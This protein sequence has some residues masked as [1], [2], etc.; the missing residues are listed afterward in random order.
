M[1]C[2]SSGTDYEASTKKIN[3][4]IKMIINDWLFKISKEKL[5]PN[6]STL[7]NVVKNTTTINKIPRNTINQTK[8]GK[9]L[10]FNALVQSSLDSLTLPDSIFKNTLS[11]LQIHNFSL[12]DQKDVKPASL[13]TFILKKEIHF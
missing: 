3:Y 7:R 9:S 4:N 10:E 1:L 13:N 12:F 8:L 6:V 2:I 11:S 5:I